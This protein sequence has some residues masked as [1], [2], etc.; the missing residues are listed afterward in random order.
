[1]W[2]IDSYLLCRSE[3]R[4]ANAKNQ[5]VHPVVSLGIRCEWQNGHKTIEIK[6]RR[7]RINSHCRFDWC[8]PA[9]CFISI[10]YKLV[11]KF[12]IVKAISVRQNAYIEHKIDNESI[13]NFNQ[14][15]AMRFGRRKI[16]Q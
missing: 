11:F 5:T 16:R 10:A 6:S 2:L 13:E 8:L 3:M 15:T 1:M 14:P 7:L 12:V 4:K 9:V